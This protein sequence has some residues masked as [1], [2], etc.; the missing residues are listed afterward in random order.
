MV[1][2]WG[3]PGT[4]ITAQG[5]AC[6]PRAAGLEFLDVSHLSRSANPTMPWL[7]Q[8]PRLRKLMLSDNHMTRTPADLCPYPLRR[9][10][11]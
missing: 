7:G 9:P 2:G 11:C 5:L 1:I 4:R 3:N 6:L 10:F 8:L